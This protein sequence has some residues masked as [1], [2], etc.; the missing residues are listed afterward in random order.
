MF[1]PTLTPVFVSVARPGVPFWYTNVVA[2]RQSVPPDPAH[3]CTDC[4]RLFSALDKIGLVAEHITTDKR[5]AARD[6]N[7]RSAS[8]ALDDGLAR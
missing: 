5:R 6:I 4:S 3:S 7:A 2:A 1:P 8:H